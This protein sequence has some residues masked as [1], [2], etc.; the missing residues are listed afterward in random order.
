MVRFFLC[1]PVRFHCVDIY[2]IIIFGNNSFHRENGTPERTFDEVFA[3]I[4]LAHKY[5][6]EDVERQALHSLRE[7]TLNDDFEAWRED[8]NE[9]I[10]VDGACAIGAV[11]LARLLDVPQMLPIALD[12]GLSLGPGILDGWTRSDGSVEYLS[13]DD[14]KRCIN[15]NRTLSV[16]RVDFTRST[17][18]PQASDK[19]RRER[20]CEDT[21]RKMLANTVKHAPDSLTDA[22]SIMETSLSDLGWYDYDYDLCASCSQEV[23]NRGVD[24]R[25]DVWRTLPDVFDIV[26]KDWGKG[27]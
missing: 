7:Y 1:S 19:C 26:V 2:T 5:N 13:Q 15:A 6:I 20:H 8:R 9:V 21:L 11:N 18:E 22:S 17:F 4:T 3:V 10:K 23:M 16:Q 24:N 12:K 14:I 27:V 25:E